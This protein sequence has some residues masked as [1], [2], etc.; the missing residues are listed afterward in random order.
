ME[1][2]RKDEKWLEEDKRYIAGWDTVKIKKWIEERP[3]TEVQW[4]KPSIERIF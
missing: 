1:D 4:V 3:C 2:D